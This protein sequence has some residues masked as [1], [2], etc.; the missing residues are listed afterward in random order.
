MA[1]D[2]EKTSDELDEVFNKFFEG[3][4]K[5]LTLIEKILFFSSGVTFDIISSCDR[6]EQDKYKALGLAVILN[7][8]LAFLSGGFFGHSLSNSSIVFVITGV[9]FSSAMYVIENLI[10]RTMDKNTSILSRIILSICIGLLV[11]I[12]MEDVILDGMIQKEMNNTYYNKKQS[13][14]NIHNDKIALANSRDGEKIAQL[15]KEIIDKDKFIYDREN[16]VIYHCRVKLDSSCDSQSSLYEKQKK[17]YKSWKA[18]KEEELTSYKK[19]VKD[20]DSQFSKDME[21]LEKNQHQDAFSKVAVVYALA[22]KDP[23]ALF[24]VLLLK[25]V[26]ILIDIIPVTSKKKLLNGQYKVKL[27]S[28]DMLR[29]SETNLREKAYLL[30][31]EEK[32][33]N[34]IK[35]KEIKE[36]S[37]S[38]IKKQDYLEASIFRKLSISD[39]IV[40]MFDSALKKTSDIVSSSLRMKTIK[41][42]ETMIDDSYR[43]KEHFEKVYH[44]SLKS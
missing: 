14:I 24:I 37:K 20:I 32:Y 6:S 22:L 9:I 18:K 33:L 10:L 8:F 29:I 12:P 42:I 25:F 43:S 19:R 23:V 7:S 2:I 36:R 13:I 26:L 35:L 1:I 28:Q 4:K 15:E 30:V 27:D 21:L 44:D 41:D 16:T 39:R 38:S 40:E 3:N 11:S 5:Q 34:L 31:T 17:E